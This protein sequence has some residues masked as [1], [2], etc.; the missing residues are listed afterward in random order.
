MNCD[1]G[2]S[3]VDEVRLMIGIL[4]PCSAVAFTLGQVCFDS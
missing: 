1:T 3:L 4:G 2:L